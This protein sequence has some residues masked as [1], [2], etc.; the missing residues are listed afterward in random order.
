MKQK[1]TYNEFK[2]EQCNYESEQFCMFKK[3]MSSK[4]TEQKCKVYRL[5]FKTAMD[6][7]RHVAQ[8]HHEEEEDMVKEKVKVKVSKSVKKLN[9][10]LK[11]PIHVK[12][13][14]DLKKTRSCSLCD[15]NCKKS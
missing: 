15:Y 13:N 5:D 9:I 10:H 2:C 7:V 8:E 11:R 6:I 1:I 3:H 14:T 12:N 4:R